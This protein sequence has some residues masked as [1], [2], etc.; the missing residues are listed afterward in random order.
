MII[1]ILPAMRGM[2]V[3]TCC[4]ISVLSDYVVSQ[5]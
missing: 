5:T 4:V 2:C 3:Y 1:D